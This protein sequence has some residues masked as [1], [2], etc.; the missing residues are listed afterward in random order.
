MRDS[1]VPRATYRVQLTPEFGFAA[2]RRL[3]PYLHALGVGDLYCSPI[4]SARSGSRHGYDVTNPHEINPELGGRIEFDALTAALHE[5]GMGLL[6]D[7]VPN[8]M[9]ASV[10]N[11]WWADVLERGIASPY[12]GYFDIEWDSAL[13]NGVL[14]NRVLLPILGAPYGQTLENGELRLALEG[15]HIVL[16]YAETALPLSL[17]SYRHILCWRLHALDAS[18][19]GEPE[20]ARAYHAL[21]EQLGRLA[22]EEET[23]PTAR[24]HQRRALRPE[25]HR[26]LG[27]PA[28]RAHLDHALAAI[29]GRPGRPRSFDL[30]DRII[31]E[32]A[33]RLAFWE[34][35]RE[36]INY[37]RFFDV[38]DLVA[39]RVEEPDVF[40]ATHQLFLE[41]ASQRQVSGLRVDHI[42]G[43]RDPLGY[44]RRLRQALAEVGA[45]DCYLVVEKILSPGES[46]PAGWPVAGTTGYDFLNELGGLFVDDAGDAALDTIYRRWSGLVVDFPELAYQQKRRVLD[47]LFAGGVN[48]LSL[49][50][51]RIAESDRHGRDLPLASLR[52]ALFELTASLTVYR[53]YIRD[54]AIAPDDRRWIERALADAARRRP[55]LSH[56]L[57]FLRR[58]LLL[59]FPANLPAE[60]RSD[61]LDFVLSWQQFTGP[62]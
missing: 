35:A 37:R 44:L 13:A 1:H 46:L 14:Q 55:E 43:L 48:E 47:D 6:L 60:E 32:Q 5:H 21:L 25:L 61:R 49:R 10:E 12:A 36:R 20:L 31:G 4:L 54:F 34:L 33:Y 58:I 29:N 53:T 40:V 41:L 11:S 28:I 16:R 22:A 59:E 15:D 3:V 26:L 9:A 57:T 17:A 7:I 52:Q 56:A 42:D 24:H 8:H 39:I 38:N 30:L 18:L 51:D 19:A 45:D 23:D 50:L 27:F 62:V 2:A